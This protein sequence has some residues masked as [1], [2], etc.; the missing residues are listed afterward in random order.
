MAQ[1]GPGS[2]HV[3]YL[4]MH[5]VPSTIDEAVVELLKER[6]ANPMRWLGERLQ[7]LGNEEEAQILAAGMPA[8]IAPV[9][10][11][12]SVTAA[13]RRAAQQFPNQV[14]TIDASGRTFTYAETADRI[15][16]FAAGLR[17]QGLATGDRVA[18]VQFNSDRFFEAYY[19][20]AWAGGAVVPINIRLAP[21]EV[22]AIIR[23]S[24]AKFLMSDDVF[25]K[26]VAGPLRDAG[27]PFTSIFTGD[28]ECPAGSVSYESLVKDHAPVPDAGRGGSDLYGIFY[29]GGTTGKAKG[30][31]LSHGNI[32]SNAMGQGVNNKYDRSTVYLHSAPMFHLADGNGTFGVTMH[33]GTHAFISRFDP[34]A[35]LAAIAKHK[36]T[37]A[38]MVPVMMTMMLREE[39]IESFD[40][41]SL[42]SIIYGASPMAPSLL[43]KMM[44]VFKSASF[45]Q[46]YGMTEC[47]PAIS[48][49]PSEHHT[50]SDP[51]LQS[52]G[53]PVPWVEV[54]IVDENDQE[55]PRGTVGE[56]TVRGPNVMTGYWGMPDATASALRGG[57]MHTGDGGRMD[58]DGFL[59]ICDR[60][61]DMII[62][63]GENVYSAEVESV[64][65][66]FDPVAQCAVIG[67][68][69][70]KLGEMVSAVVVPK[71]GRAA[72]ITEDALKAFCKER[73]AGYKCPRRV[74]VK[75]QLPISGAGKVLKHEVRKEF[76]AGHELSETYAKD[77]KTTQYK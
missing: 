15:A 44:S 21:P 12:M 1:Q 69:D 38:M 32:V 10:Q 14:A 62:T 59:W 36:V 48:M 68:P 24:G 3:D 45:M 77:G 73:I 43:E 33:A 76:W 74:F 28:G 40:F 70:E 55:V 58:E 67:T 35:M 22:V 72:E 52:V 39:S 47:S 5:K 19:A 13:I 30:V 61:K 37:H 54:R 64:I 60:I 51:K 11:G 7:A 23:D 46:G 8:R 29:T 9:H 41:S 17:A 31:M 56:I 16:R 18:I 2:Q 4:R 50:P 49:C 65:M 25:T 75:E 53:R 20:V 63:G 34:K 27:V 26:A 57:W 42:H 71:P 66:A 6:P